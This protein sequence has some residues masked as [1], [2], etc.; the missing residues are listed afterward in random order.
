MDDGR[1]A[2]SLQTR[3][4]AAGIG[5]DDPGPFSFASEPRVRGIL[6]EAGF[7]SIAMDLAIFSLDV[8]VGRGLEAAV[9]GA[10]EI[11]PVSRALEGQSPE[12]MAT[13]ANAIRTAY[14]PLAE[15]GSIPLGGSV[16]IVTAAR[17]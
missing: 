17:S 3:S 2:G 5:P 4:A 7:S 12:V 10:L 8:A 16:W 14:A 6:D 13:V 11:G 9:R 15:G 1:A